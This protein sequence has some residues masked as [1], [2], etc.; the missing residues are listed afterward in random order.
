M[1]RYLH[2]N[3]TN[4]TSKYKFVHKTSSPYHQQVNGNAQNA[5]KIAKH[6]LEK[7]KRTTKTLT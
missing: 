5:V 1:D 7:A 4:F 2:L 3:F 6:I